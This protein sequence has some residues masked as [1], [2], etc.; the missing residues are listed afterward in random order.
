MVALVNTMRNSPIELA[1]EI[2]REAPPVITGVATVMPVPNA[3]VIVFA[4][5]LLSTVKYKEVQRA[6]VPPN[7]VASNVA[8]GR[9]IVVAAALV[10]VIYPDTIWAAVAVAVALI[11]FN[12]GL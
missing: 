12:V 3:M 10:E 5:A 4:P 8:V 7:C 1:V 11:A 2:V 9:V 6:T